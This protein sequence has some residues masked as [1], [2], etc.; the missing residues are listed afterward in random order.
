MLDL[1]TYFI[2]PD[3]VAQSN[4]RYVKKTTQLGLILL[5]Y[6]STPPW[7]ELMS[8]THFSLLTER[9]NHGRM[10]AEDVEYEADPQGGDK[11]YLTNSPSYG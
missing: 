6:P 9:P 10:Y 8:W 1:H 5:I 3:L 4:I 11:I 2:Q 7:V